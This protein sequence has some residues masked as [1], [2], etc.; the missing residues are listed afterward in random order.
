MTT[1]LA[2]KG[3]RSGVV[4]RRTLSPHRGRRLVVALYPGDLIGLRQERSRT[5]YVITLAGVFDFAARVHAERARAERAAKR[6]A[7]RY[8]YLRQR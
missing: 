6:K 8:S 7:R 1:A 3:G 5:E 2:R 4:K